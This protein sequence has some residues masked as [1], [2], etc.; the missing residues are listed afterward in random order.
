M[1]SSAAAST[2]LVVTALIV[3]IS[4]LALYFIVR[5]AVSDGMKN[6]ARWREETG[7]DVPPTTDGSAP[8]AP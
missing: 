2:G 3:A 6:Y 8:P 4:L 1:Y 7:R 5:G